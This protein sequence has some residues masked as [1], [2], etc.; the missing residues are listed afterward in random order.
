MS[1]TPTPRPESVG[2]TRGSCRAPTW[3]AALAAG[4]P[5]IHY[6]PGG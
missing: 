2:A 5:G 1:G 6:Q 4:I 3:Y